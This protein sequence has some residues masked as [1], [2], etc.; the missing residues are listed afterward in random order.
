MFMAR[1]YS[2]GA[3]LCKR[4]LRGRRKSLVVHEEGGGEEGRN[5]ERKRKSEGGRRSWGLGYRRWS[6]VGRSR[7][8]D[9][10]TGMVQAAHSPSLI[11]IARRKHNIK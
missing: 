9:P 4:K 2:Y 3:C 5:V 1:R 6:Y 8:A 11:F 7:H 10:D